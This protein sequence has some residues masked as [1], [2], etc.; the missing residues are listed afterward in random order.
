MKKIDEIKWCE[1]YIKNK[2]KEYKNWLEA[3][4]IALCNGDEVSQEAINDGDELQIQV[5]E[6]IITQEEK[7]KILLEKFKK[8]R[9]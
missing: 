9:S 5:W 3:R 4:A 6:G 7:R 2:E 8:G 1:K